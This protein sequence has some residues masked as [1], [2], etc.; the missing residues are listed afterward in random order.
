MRIGAPEVVAPAMGGGVIMLFTG[1]IE[2]LV[3]LSLV[4]LVLVLVLV[5]L[6]LL[7]ESSVVDAVSL[8]EELSDCTESQ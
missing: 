8:E 1:S 7:L 4:V 5:L 3:M 6:T 2:E